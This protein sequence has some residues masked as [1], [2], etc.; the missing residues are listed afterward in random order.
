LPK[1]E[2]RQRL[3]ASV[4]NRAFASGFPSSWVV[5]ASVSGGPNVINRPVSLRST[6]DGADAAAVVAM[7]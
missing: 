6:V 4:P 2:N 3:G 1:N 7:F 5:V